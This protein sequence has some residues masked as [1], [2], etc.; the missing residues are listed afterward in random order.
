VTRVVMRPPGQSGKAK[1]GHL[2]FDASFET[3]KSHCSLGSYTMIP[4]KCGSISSGVGALNNTP[5]P[6]I[7][8]DLSL[9]AYSILKQVA[10]CLSS[11]CVSE[12][13]HCC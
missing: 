2:C 8:P 1:R 10:H 11:D 5:V 7:S 13:K 4:P 12:C 6:G 3:G 9:F